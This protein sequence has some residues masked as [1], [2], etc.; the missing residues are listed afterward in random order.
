MTYLAGHVPGASFLD[1]EADL[2]APPGGGGTR[3]GIRCRIGGICASCREGG[4]RGRHARRRLRPGNERRRGATLVAP[5]PLRARRCRSPARRAGRLARPLRAGEERSSRPSSTCERARTTFSAEI[6]ERLGRPG[7]VVVDARAPER[8]RGEVEPIDS[9]AATSRAQSTCRTHDRSSSRSRLIRGRRRL[10]R[11]AS[12][13]MRDV[14]D[15]NRAG[16][17]AKLYPGSWSE[18]SSARLGGRAWLTSPSGRHGPTTPRPSSS[19]TPTGRRRTTA[20][21]RSGA[22]CTPPSWPRPT[23]RSSPS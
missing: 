23:A 1:V 13:G 3:G 12:H 5:A 7:F 2:S 22:R 17:R 9:V 15:S 6:E 4:D 20:R 21:S 18:W 8:Y 14:L 11:P 16:V 19:C 10:L